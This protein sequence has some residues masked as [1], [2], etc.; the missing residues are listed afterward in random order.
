MPEKRLAPYG[1]WVSPVTPNSVSRQIRL[2]D[3]QWT[4][5]G[6]ALL[7]LEGR[8]GKGVLVY[9][10]GAEIPKD[11]TEDHNVRGGVG[12]GGG[13]FAP[14]NS[15]AVFAEKDGRL[16]RVEYSGGAPRP[17]TP[18]FGAAAGPTLSPDG[19]WV[20]YVHSYENEDSLVLAD[21]EGRDWP[22]RLVRGADF[23]MQPAWHPRGDRIAWVDWNF[24]NM[25]WDGT[26]LRSARIDFDPPRLGEVT[27]VAGAADVPVFQPAFSPDGAHL[28]YIEERGEWDS[29][30]VMELES[31]KK[32][33]LVADAVLSEPAW[34]QGLRTF[35][36]SGDG[37]KIFFI[38]REQG[39]GSLHAVDVESGRSTPLPLSPYTDQAQIAVS[40]SANELA[41]VA[42]S[43][44][45]PK[46]IVVQHDKRILVQAQACP[47]RLGAEEYSVP[48]PFTWRSEEGAEVHGLFFPAHNPRYSAKDP[49]PAILL[50]HGGPTSQVPA[51]YS[52]DT[53]FF[54]SR[55]YACL[56]V[57]Y[58][59]STGFGRSYRNALRGRWGEADVIDTVAG[60]RA[61][62][63]RGLADPRRLVVKGGSAGGYTVLNC[64]IRHP[65]VFC[66]GICLYGVA[67]LFTIQNEADKFEMRYLD[68]LVGA[69][70]EARE[71]YHDWSP[72]FHAD[73]IRDPLAVFQGEEDTAVPPG[74]SEEIVRALM[75]SGVPHLYRRFPGEGHGWR[76]AE[77]I[78][79]YYTEVQEFLSRYVLFA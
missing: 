4:P 74:Q 60:A 33:T 56:A 75:R 61:L 1:T 78:V 26:V 20:L 37:R 18:G 73:R 9:R 59:G 65:G 49:P 10:K 11:L 58:R 77:T 2:E 25:P 62:V 29:L 34:T 50:V 14:G 41:Y 45:I 57:N 16:H 68:T 7:W 39:V 3:V 19:R 24:P 46:R 32:R 15:F 47:E 21:S 38:R 67:N 35:G 66:A 53:A 69:L 23:Y 72:V 13:A 76:K 40:S 27:V 52:A 63:E 70:P 36:W 28:A 48:E 17:I 51:A 31:G 55:G 30:I 5:D 6:G 44:V 12:Y 22:R 8:S 79:S 42:S 64:L 43:C 54:T 71:K